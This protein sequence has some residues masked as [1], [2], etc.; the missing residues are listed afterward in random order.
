MGKTEQN[1][2]CVH[3]DRRASVSHVPDGEASPGIIGGTSW[4]LWDLIRYPYEGG[5][6][7]ILK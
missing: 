5:D 6:S 7:N 3:T 1:A 4:F 2:V